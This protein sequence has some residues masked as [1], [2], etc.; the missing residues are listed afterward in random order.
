MPHVITDACIRDGACAEVCPVDGIVPGMP[1]D[2][3]PTYYIDPESCID[4]GACEAECET[5]AIMAIED[6][7]EDMQHFAE[8]NARFFSE[9]PGYAAL[10]MV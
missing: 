9:G 4:C 6:L 8:I 10:D 1:E 2:E 3:W 5:G 7:P